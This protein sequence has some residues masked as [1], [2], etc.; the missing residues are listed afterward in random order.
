MS[1]EASHCWHTILRSIT[2]AFADPRKA[3]AMA[4]LVVC[5][6]ELQQGLYR[7]VAARGETGLLTLQRLFRRYLDL[8]CGGNIDG[9][10]MQELMGELFAFLESNAPEEFAAYAPHLLACLGHLRELGL[11]DLD[12]D[13]RRCDPSFAGFVGGVAAAVPNPLCPPSPDACAT[14]YQQPQPQRPS[15]TRP[16]DH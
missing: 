9:G 5:M 1:H 13:L 2:S 11:C 6:T 10:A 3:E 4:S 16:H 8:W 12:I 15:Q 7:A 14:P